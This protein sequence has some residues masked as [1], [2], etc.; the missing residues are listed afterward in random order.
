MEQLLRHPWV[1]H[2]TTL[3]QVDI[4]ASYRAVSSC[5]FAPPVFDP[6]QALDPEVVAE[7]ARFYS[8]DALSM[9]SHIGEVCRTCV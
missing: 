9:A 5:L 2:G 4:H 7:M 3:A 1:L 6:I 8:T